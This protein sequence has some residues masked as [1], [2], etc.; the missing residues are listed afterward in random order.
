MAVSENTS[1]QIL[2]VVLHHDPHKG[3][4]SFTA[5]EQNRRRMMFSFSC[6]ASETPSLFSGVSRS[7][8]SASGGSL[9]HGGGYLLDTW[10]QRVCSLGHLFSHHFYS[11]LCDCQ[12]LRPSPI[13]LQV[14]LVS[15][16][17]LL[18]Q[19]LI[20]WSTMVINLFRSYVSVTCQFVSMVLLRHSTNYK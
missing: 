11:S 3:L 10:F 12:V 15:F 18:A 5:C 7:F 6:P 16:G 13:Y 19:I 1:M 17:H 8:V 20:S 14:C 4:S 2:L 9:W